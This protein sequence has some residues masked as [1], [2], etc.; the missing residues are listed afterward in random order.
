M[1]DVRL[2]T[3]FPYHP[4]TRLLINALGYEAVFCLQTLWLFAASERTSGRLT[5]M[6]SQDIESAAGW[7]GKDAVFT[8]HL[9]KFKWLEYRRGSYALHNWKRRQPYI[10]DTK[11]RQ[12]IARNAANTRWEKSK[13]HAP[14]IPRA[15][16]EGCSSDAPYRTVPNQQQLLS[17]EKPAAPKPDSATK[18]IRELWCQRFQEF[19]GVA[20]T[21]SGPKDGAAIKRLL[22]THK[23]TVLVE[24]IETQAWCWKNEAGEPGG[25]EKAMRK[26]VEYLA[27]VKTI[28][29][30]A[31]N[32]NNVVE[33]FDPKWKRAQ[34]PEAK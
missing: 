32:F 30:W 17:A 25:M 33:Y 11:K 5:K 19:F 6:T 31:S 28:A 16:L 9:I 2:Y 21:F 15:M 22:A 13:G 8:A 1:R 10:S 34:L 7:N 24:G 20:Y 14:S 12:E 18:K 3:S 4:K 23:L 27:S 26:R 29:L